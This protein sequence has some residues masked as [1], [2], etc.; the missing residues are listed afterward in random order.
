MSEASP[1]YTALGWFGFFGRR[2][3][4]APVI[5]A[6]NGAANAALAV[7]EVLERARMLDLDPE[8]GSAADLEKMWAQDFERWG[9]VYRGLKLS[10]Q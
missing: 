9:R 6:I 7:P 10:P 4:P 5:T 2:G 1:G 3:V 8:P